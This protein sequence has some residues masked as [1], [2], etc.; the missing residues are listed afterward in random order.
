M[1]DSKEAVFDAL[2]IE[3]GTASAKKY[4]YNVYEYMLYN[5]TPSFLETLNFRINLPEH[6]KENEEYYVFKFMLKLL[7]KRNKNKLM[8]LCPN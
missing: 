1:K 3:I 2:G 4:F 6:E 7:K 5:D 8:S